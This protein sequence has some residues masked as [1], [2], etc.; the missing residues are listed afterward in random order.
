MKLPSDDSI[1]VRKLPVFLLVDV[2]E[3]MNGPGIMQ[4]NEGLRTFVEDLRSDQAGNIVLMTLMTFSDK[5][6]TVFQFQEPSAIQLRQLITEGRTELDLA[7]HALC[8]LVAGQPKDLIRDLKAPLL[9]IITDGN[10]TCTD[11]SLDAAIDRLNNDS[12]FG[13]S[14]TTNSPR[15]FRLICGAGSEQDVSE[16]VLESLIHSKEA[17]AVK[18]LH[19][20]NSLKLFFHYLNTLTRQITMNKPISL[21]DDLVNS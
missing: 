14:S 11:A 21:D 2:S 13:R 10:P 3:S 7:L 8:D 19:D 15:G 18:R 12:F 16:E 20:V 9:C 6:K 4:A 5:A 17:G 1:T